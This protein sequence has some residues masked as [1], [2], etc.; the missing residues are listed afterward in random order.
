LPIERSGQL[1]TASLA[2]HLSVAV[3]GAV[4]LSAPL[5][6]GA[7]PR[8]VYSEDWA[9]TPSARYAALDSRACLA[10]L[11]KRGVEVELVD[12]APGV[13]APLRLPSGAGGVLFRTALPAL[14]RAQSP[15]DVFDCRLALALADFGEILS[16][17]GVVEVVILSAWRPATEPIPEGRPVIRHPGGLAVDVARLRLAP[18]KEA[19]TGRWVEID[20]S[21][22]PALGRPPCGEGASHVPDDDGARVLHGAVCEAADKRLFTSILTPNYDRAHKNHVHLEITPGVTWH[23]TR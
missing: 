13:M 1:R 22:A 19:P 16:T 9:D 10:E 4:L 12:R 18:T 5:G 21:W 20:E 8:V 14:E 7:K 17:R 3:A 15:S 6:A 11:A 23:L 2:R